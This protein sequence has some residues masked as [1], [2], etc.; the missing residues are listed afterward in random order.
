M[1]TGKAK[2]TICQVMKGDW[3]NQQIIDAAFEVLDE[4]N[5]KRDQQMQLLE[6]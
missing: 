6:S 2:S 3:H 1:K 4:L 5:K